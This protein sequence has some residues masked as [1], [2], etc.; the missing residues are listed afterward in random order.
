MYFK[1]ADFIESRPVIIH[2]ISSVYLCSDLNLKKSTN[3][4][5][6]YN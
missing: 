2:E 1:I 6:E 4:R 3:N 5:Q